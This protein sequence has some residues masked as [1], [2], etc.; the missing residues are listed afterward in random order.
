M[1]MTL[2]SATNGVTLKGIDLTGTS[3][4]DSKIRTCVLNVTST[5]SGSATAY[6]VYSAGT[7]STA[8]S[9]A[10]TVRATTINVSYT[11]T[12]GVA[13]AV[14][15]NGA[16]RVSCRDTNI[17]ATGASDPSTENIIGCETASAGSYLD[18]KTCSIFGAKADISQ[19]LGTLLFSNGSDLVHNNANGYGFQVNSQPHMMTFAAVGNIDFH[20]NPAYFMPGSMKPNDIPTVPTYIPFDLPVL[21]HSAAFSASPA[22]SVGDTATFSVFK[23]TSSLTT[24]TLMF[25]AALTNTNSLIF[26]QGISSF[27]MSP[28]EYML[29]QCTSNKN[30]GNH[31]IM[32][33]IQFV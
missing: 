9:S 4:R 25:N 12:G 14:Y 11:G 22:L 33:N 17:Y 24:S 30:I 1:T 28:Y 19:T 26:L 18:V 7:S 31:N 6:G 32:A 21:V 15:V 29:V 3:A 23:Y 13:R 5:A 10:N 16:N 27:K 20:T 2:T 8:L